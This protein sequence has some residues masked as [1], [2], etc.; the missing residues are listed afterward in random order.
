M[1]LHTKQNGVASWES[2]GHVPIITH[3]HNSFET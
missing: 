1:T 3:Q 2:T